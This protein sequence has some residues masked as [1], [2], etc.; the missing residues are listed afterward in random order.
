MENNELALILNEH[1]NWHKSRMCCFVGML[2]SLVK[3]RTVNLTELACGFTS[4]AQLDS[5]YKRIKRFFKE[6]NIEYSVECLFACLKSKGFNFEDTHITQLD[7]IE[8]LLVL[9]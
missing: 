3:V 6:F 5:R 1:F 8:K 2:L 7:R 4:T 9:W